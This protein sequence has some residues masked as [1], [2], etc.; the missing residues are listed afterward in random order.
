MS[1]PTDPLARRL[2]LLGAV[3]VAAFLA[4]AVLAA[5]LAAFS[6]VLI[7]QGDEIAFVDRLAANLHWLPGAPDYLRTAVRGGLPL[8]NPYWRA[9]AATLPVGVASI[10]MLLALGAATSAPAEEVTATADRMAVRVA[11]T[12]V[13]VAAFALPSYTPDFWLSVAWGRMLGAGQNAYYA[14]FTPEVFQGIPGS[15]FEP[16]ERLTYGPLWAFLIGGVGRL[17]SRQVLWEFLLHKML[18]A[19]AWLFT[20]AALRR[21][22][23]RRGAR[24]RLL[25]T[26]LIGWLPAGV[27][28]AVAEGHND[29]VMVMFVSL[30][31]EAVDR[32]DHRLAPLWLACSCLIKFITLPLVGLELLAARRAG[33]L[34]SRRYLLTL[35]ACGAGSLLALLAFYDGPGFL[36][37]TR[38]MQ[39]WIFWVPSSYVVSV[40]RYL[41][42]DLPLVRI[43]QGFAV[44]GLLATGLV[45]LRAARRPGWESWVLGALAVVAY[46]LLALVGH[47]WPWFALWLVPFLGAL[48]PARTAGVVLAFVLMVPFLNLGWI[49]A[50]EWRLRPLVEIPMYSSVLVV[51]GFYLLRRVAAKA[52]TPEPAS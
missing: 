12:L 22:A 20:L 48:W 51:L 41:G 43:D 28:F 23:G 25:V 52:R 19:S 4:I 8:G 18:L 30:W 17:A 31:L 13:L 11:V 16:Q 37:A 1:G 36:G 9:L 33:V 7:L 15:D 34:L 10:A 29:V 42:V 44:L 45:L 27:Y 21:L 50:G 6:P 47:V 3:S 35:A 40:A 49:L 14:P 32:G 46:L 39:S 5:G 26:C 2:A 38:S 24:E